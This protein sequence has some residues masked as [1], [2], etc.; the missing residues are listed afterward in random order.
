MPASRLPSTRCGSASAACLTPVEAQ[1][2]LDHHLVRGGAS[3]HRDRGQH[4]R[5]S[6]RSRRCWPEGR[7]VGDKELSEYMEVRG[8][9]DAAQWVYSQGLAGGE[10]T[11]GDILNLTEV[12]QVHR[13]TMQPVWD[14]APH[15]NATDQ[16]LTG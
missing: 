12:R 14:V 1:G 8:Y 3:L 15:P 2:H 7:A 9:A 6:N 10:W 11:T 5:R 4:A 16:E 13:M